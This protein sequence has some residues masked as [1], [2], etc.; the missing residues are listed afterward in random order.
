MINEN[1]KSKK[2]NVAFENTAF[3]QDMRNGKFNF[4]AFVN[5]NDPSKIITQQGKWEWWKEIANE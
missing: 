3:Y 4:N 1:R 5:P 2:N